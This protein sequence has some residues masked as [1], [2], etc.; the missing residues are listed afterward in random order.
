MDR[1][2]EEQLKPLNNVI[3]V[4]LICG[5]VDAYKNDGHDYL[6]SIQNQL[7]QEYYD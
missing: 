6:L 1:L 2:E 5:K 7:A 3:Q 4:C